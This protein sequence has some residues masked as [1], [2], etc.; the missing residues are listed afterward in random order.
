MVVGDIVRKIGGVQKYK[1]EEINDDK[2]IC[3]LYPHGNP[4]LKYTFKLSELE[5]V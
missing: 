3:I 2:A 1:I 4:Q 5:K